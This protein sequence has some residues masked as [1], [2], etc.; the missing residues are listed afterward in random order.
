MRVTIILVPSIHPLA[1]NYHINSQL[2]IKDSDV[3]WNEV[4]ESFLKDST[5][6]QSTYSNNGVVWTIID[7]NNV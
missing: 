5:V 2:F 1:T 3:S 7:K 4:L 6:L